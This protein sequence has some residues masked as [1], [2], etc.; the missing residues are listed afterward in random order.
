MI[1]HSL[2]TFLCVV[3]LASIG[4]AQDG[5]FAKL[6]ILHW[7]DFHSQN[8]PM[9]L[10]KKNDDGSR[11]TYDCGGAAYMKAYVDIYKAESKETL[12]LHAG[13][14]F[15]GTP[16]SSITKGLSQI[17]LLNFLLPDVMTIGNHEFDYGADNLRKI[18]PLLK[19]PIIS[20][21]IFDKSKGETFLP[22]YEIVQRGALKIGVI[23]L[24]PDDL[25]RLTMRENVKDLDV[26][27]AKKVTT[28]LVNE[29][30]KKHDVNMI[31]VLSHCGVESDVSLAKAV[32]GID[33][34]I[35]GHSHT[36]L[37][38]PKRENG[39]IICQ[40]GAKGRYLG[41][42]DLTF[43][44]EKGKMI[45]SDGNLIETVNEG[46]T[47]DSVVAAKVAELEKQVDASMNETIGTLTVDW[48]RSGK[49]ESNVGNWQADVI[50]DF[51]KTDIAFQ[52]SGGIRKNLVAGP[53]TMRDMWEMAPF[54][55]EFTKFSVTGEQLQSMLEWQ[56]SS[57][58]GELCQVSGLKYI[59]D[60]SK[61]AKS[62]IG[63]LEVNGQRFDA[64]NTYSI[65]TN[66]YVSGHLHDVFGLPEKEITVERV[67]PVHVDR[68][69]FIDYIKKQKQITSKVEGRIDIKGEA[70]S[71]WDE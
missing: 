69:V 42:L 4:W 55:N 51:A 23:G 57:A 39:V 56:A 53:I 47:P 46:I 34:I 9:K 68:D 41:K 24:A 63:I 19:F 29:L 52:N 64:N 62:R 38:H 18:L 44:L 17:E 50:R 31:V 43:D 60:K 67:L 22:Q 36:P 13:D 37:M 6:T 16:I 7:N 10:S 26:L 48:I 58:K 66:N 1:K 20:A 2:R 71:N 65:S 28:Q 12:V 8:I 70:G 25:A 21:N 49:K 11:I 61:P 35:G 3:I 59:M 33:V 27:D 5:N 14:D 30:R 45:S 40:A 15:Q 32:Q 54:G